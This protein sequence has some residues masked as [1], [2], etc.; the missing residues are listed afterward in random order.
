VTRWSPRSA[1]VAAALALVATA[2]VTPAGS[3]QALSS[4]CEGGRNGFVDIPDT[5]SGTVQRDLFLGLGAKE[6]Y[7]ETGQVGGVQRGWAMLNGGP[8]AGTDL[9]WMDWTRDG[10]STWLQC[11]PF[12]VGDKPSKTSAAQATSSDP[13]WRFRACADAGTGIRCTDWW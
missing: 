2:F 4:D 8:L 6:L 5:L 9:V 11:G 10:G 13:R 7:L 3:A 12:S 1:A